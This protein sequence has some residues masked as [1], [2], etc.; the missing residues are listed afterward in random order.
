[1]TYEPHLSCVQPFDEEVAVW[2]F[3]DLPKFLELLHSESLYFSRLDRFE[4]PYEGHATGEHL[5]SI[6]LSFDQKVNELYDMMRKENRVRFYVN[7]WHLTQ[8]EPASM[9][10]QYASANAGIAICSTYRQLKAVLEASDERVFL[11]LV[12][13]AGRRTTGPIQPFDWIMSK[14]PSFEHEKEVRAFIWR[15]SSD[16]SVPLENL[17]IGLKVKVILQNLLEEVVVSPAAPDWLPDLLEG[18]MDKFGIDTVAVRRSS[19]YE[20]PFL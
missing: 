10:K 11:G 17:P 5:A 6:R 9:W 2:R 20:E 3:L 8:H 4:D 16:A 15:D 14:R 18:V 12:Q 7:S 1:M 13:Y 19:L